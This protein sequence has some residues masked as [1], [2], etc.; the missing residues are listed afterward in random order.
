M[1][2]ISKVLLGH[3]IAKARVLATQVSRL[4]QELYFQAM[5]ELGLIA[6]VHNQGFEKLD[7]E[8]SA[9]SDRTTSEKSVSCDFPSHVHGSIQQRERVTLIAELCVQRH[10]GD[11]IETGAYLN[12]HAAIHHSL[13]REGY[14]LPPH[15]LVR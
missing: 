10:P 13:C 5:E 7:P 11:L 14:L 2:M 3:L 15:F 1:S 6:E 9:I 8:L 4:G 12:R